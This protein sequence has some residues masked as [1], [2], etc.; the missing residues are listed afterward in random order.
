MRAGRIDERHDDQHRDQRRRGRDRA[1]VRIDRIIDPNTTADPDVSI[2]LPFGRCRYCSTDAIRSRSRPFQTDSPGLDGIDQHHAPDRAVDLGER[3]AR[4]AGAGP[5]G[6]AR[7][8]RAAGRPWPDLLALLVV[9]HLQRRVVRQ[10]ADL[11]DQ[12]QLALLHL[13]RPGQQVVDRRDLADDVGARAARRPACGSSRG[14]ARPRR[15]SQPGRW[16]A[17][18]TART[19]CRCCD[20]SAWTRSVR[21]QLG[22]QLAEVVL[23]RVLQEVRAARTPTRSIPAVSTT[24]Q[25]RAPA[26]DEARQRPQF[27]GARTGPPARVP[28]DVL[29]SSDQHRRQHREGRQPA[30]NRARPRPSRRTGRSRGSWSPSATRRPPTPQIAA[31]S[32]PRQMPCSASRSAVAGSSPRARCSS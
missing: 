21:V 12:R 31:T 30:G 29:S 13:G 10:L 19:A 16:S 25:R 18:A 9:E 27:S 3:P 11:R 14:S 4:D 15:S 7:A 23:E 22:V 26:L 28:A 5:S 32:V 2:T 6:P 17:T 8:A 1:V 24:H 20:R